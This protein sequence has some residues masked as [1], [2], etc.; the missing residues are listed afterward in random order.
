MWNALVNATTGRDPGLLP[1]LFD[2]V[3]GG[4]IQR[5]CGGAGNE[6][7]EVPSCFDVHGIDL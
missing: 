5:Q 2:T 6:D 7:R 4:A 3:G 1:G